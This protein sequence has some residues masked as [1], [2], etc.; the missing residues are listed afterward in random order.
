MKKRHQ[1]REAREI[2]LIRSLLLA[3]TRITTQR[4]TRELSA[5]QAKRH[6]V[7][8]RL[9]ENASALRASVKTGAVLS[10]SAFECAYASMASIEAKQAAIRTEVHHAADR[11]KQQ[12]LRHASALRQSELAD[13]R[14]ARAATG[15]RKFDELRSVDELSQRVSARSSDT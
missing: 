15:V 2:A 3:R 10:L 7:E 5:A 1:L 12:Q 13:E 8:N 4:L 6:D 11:L 14:V 9:L